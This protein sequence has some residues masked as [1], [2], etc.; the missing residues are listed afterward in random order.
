MPT[1]EQARSWYPDPDPV[2]GFDHVWRVYHMAERLAEVEGADLEIV[3]AAALL[4]DAEG[5]ATAG[6]DEGRVDHHQASA[7]FARQILSEEGWPEERIAAVEHCIRAHRFRDETE[8]PRTLEAKILFDADK[9]DVLGAIG[10]VRTI[11]FDV[12]VGQPI[13]SEPSDRFINT[14]EKEP[15]EPHSSV[16]EYFFKLSKIKDRLYTSPAR[17]I[18]EQRH[19]FMADFF[20]RLGAELR[21]DK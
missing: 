21:G 13:Y 3:R 18:A 4:H 7:E 20:D 10:I 11:A 14:G 8:M 9:L 19:Q 12:V 17:T 2:H 6:G 5:S 15:G 16:H 1:L